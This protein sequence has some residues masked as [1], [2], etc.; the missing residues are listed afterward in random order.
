MKKRDDYGSPA[1]SYF[2]SMD[3][4]IAPLAAELRI[5]ILKTVL[6][7]SELI[8]WGTPVY[9]WNGYVCA[10]RA[11]KDYVALQFG[12]VAV[13]LDDPN[14]LLQ[15]T[16]KQYRHVKVHSQSDI[17]KTLFSSWIRQTAEANVK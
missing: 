7:L 16:G 5:L 6:R 13:K 15:G 17:R 12:A 10:I 8:K 11:G 9:E 2:K 4:H 14:K 3:E 1:D